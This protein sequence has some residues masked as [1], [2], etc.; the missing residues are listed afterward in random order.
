MK[1]V[2][3]AVAV[4]VALTLA[5][6][7]AAASSSRGASVG[8]TRTALGRIAVDAQGRSL[9]LFEIDKRGHS[10]CSGLCTSYWPPLITKGKPVALAGIKRSL[11][12]TIRRS[13]G[14]LQV[15]LAGHP[16]YRFSGDSKRGQTTGEGLQDFGG[17]W[18][19]LT[20]SGK[21]IEGGG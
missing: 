8:T 14:R 20:P 1:I 6:V 18:D 3:I 10:A 9:Y 4:A 5:G 2:H 15:T 17:G 16:L 21:K 11:L 13:D 7:S 12:G 19:V